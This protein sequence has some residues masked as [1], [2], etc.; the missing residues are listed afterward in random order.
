M[1]IGDHEMLSKTGRGR[2]GQRLYIF[3]FIVL[4]QVH[5]TGVLLRTSNTRSDSQRSPIRER[6]KKEGYLYNIQDTAT[7][8]ADI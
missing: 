3:I 7:A 1:S 4:A 2:S 5:N 8:L 6:T